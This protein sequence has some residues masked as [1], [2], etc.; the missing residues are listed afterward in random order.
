MKKESTTTFSLERT[1]LREVHACEAMLLML[2]DPDHLSWERAVTLAIEDVTKIRTL[3]NA[4]A[5]ECISRGHD[6]IA[7]HVETFAQVPLR[8]T[9]IK[10]DEHFVEAVG[11]VRQ[12]LNGSPEIIVITT[13]TTNIPSDATEK[14]KEEYVK[15]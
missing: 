6:A 10:G 3:R 4:I 13:G 8:F 5:R 9:K 14:G 7:A 11:I 1:G 15:D 2:V 12:L